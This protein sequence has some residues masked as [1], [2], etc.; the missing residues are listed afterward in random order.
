MKNFFKLLKYTL[1]LIFSFTVLACSSLLGSKNMEHG[2]SV[3]NNSE[4][5]ISNVV[6]HYGDRFIKFCE[7]QCYGKRSSGVYGV[8]MPI[9]REM[10]V[11]WKTE[12]GL[13]H[14]IRVPVKEKIIDIKRFRR[15]FLEFN[16]ERLVVK[17]GAYFL[18]PGEVGWEES[19][20]FP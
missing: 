2:F 9:Q 11:T 8:N 18:I 4:K 3:K 16:D 5:K 6:I 15:L 1:I 10:S 19:P 20:L 13:K 7:M 14:E 17:Q 12:N